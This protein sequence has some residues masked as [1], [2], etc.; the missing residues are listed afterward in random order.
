MFHFNLSKNRLS[1]VLVILAPI[2]LGIWL[3]WPNEKTVSGQSSVQQ[4]SVI[5]NNINAV[6]EPA[7]FVASDVSSVDDKSVFSC[8]IEPAQTVEIRSSVLGVVEKITVERGDAVKKG[9]ML[10]K[11]DSTITQATVAGARQRAL[12]RA[13]ID[14]ARQKL[15]LANVKVERMEQ[16]YRQEFV[17]AQARDDAINERNIAETEFKQALENQRIAQLD[18]KTSLA[19]LGERT[20]TSP[21]DGVV[22]ARYVD[23]GT[24]VSATDN[25]QPI[26]RLVQ[27]DRLKLTAILP[28]KYFQNIQ[29]GDTVTVVPESPFNQPIK[30]TVIKKDQVVDAA[31]GTFGI[32]AYI[33]NK[34][35]KLPSGIL[36]QL[37]I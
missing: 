21:F 34:Q 25:K 9:Q 30:I 19:E 27:I 32:V 1:I 31:S 17:S 7:K 2:G 23:V 10:V 20:I 35:Y 13:Q 5:H 37:D 29:E 36:C 15:A 3:L 12:A 33:D 6:S 11:L 24:V 18:Y 16:M 8:M 4:Q 22:S 14:G 28:F 26:L